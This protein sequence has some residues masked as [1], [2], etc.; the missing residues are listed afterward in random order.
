MATLSRRGCTEGEDIYAP[1]SVDSKGEEEKA[2]EKPK[3]GGAKT[4]RELEAIAA[5]MKSQTY[6]KLE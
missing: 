3:D 1:P 5:F 4:P 2:S 6:G